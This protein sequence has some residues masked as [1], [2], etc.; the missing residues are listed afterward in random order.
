MHRY[1]KYYRRLNFLTH[2][3]IMSLLQ[4]PIVLLTLYNI[5]LIKPPAHLLLFRKFTEIQLMRINYDIPMSY[6]AT[7]SKRYLNAFIVLI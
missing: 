3:P 4:L 5:L 6:K 2:T 1:H 7:V